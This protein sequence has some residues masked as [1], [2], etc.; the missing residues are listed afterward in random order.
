M[1]TK[2]YSPFTCT[3]S[4]NSPSAFITERMSGMAS[5]YL[6]RSP[7][8]CLWSG[9]NTLGSRPTSLSQWDLKVTS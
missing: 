8:C 3:S 2:K 1:Q 4:R 5:G 7:E 6:C 9:A